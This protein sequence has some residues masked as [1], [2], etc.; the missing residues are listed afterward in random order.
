[1]TGAP[2]ELQILVA[3]HNPPRSIVIGGRGYG[4]STVPALR[5]ARAGWTVRGQPFG[6]VLVKVLTSGGTAHVELS[7]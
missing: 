2:R 4:R 6:G 1:V 7:F 5:R 3:L